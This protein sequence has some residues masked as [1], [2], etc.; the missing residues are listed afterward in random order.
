MS[1]MLTM[2]RNHGG[3]NHAYGFWRPIVWAIAVNLPLL[4]VSYV[5]SKS[6]AS[7]EVGS[8]SMV[9][10]LV[11]I[12]LLAATYVA[13]SRAATRTGWIFGTVSVL[14]SFAGVMTVYW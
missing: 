1:T 8:S 5:T 9:M 2:A 13:S 14:A 3:A 4:I 6:G 10:S 11:S 12:T 7:I